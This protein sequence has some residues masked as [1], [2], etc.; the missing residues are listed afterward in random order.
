MKD[1]MLLKAL[2][3]KMLE[4]TGLGV[5][6]VTKIAQLV[7]S[8]RS[9][10]KLAF[11]D[12]EL[13]GYICGVLHESPFNNRRRVSDIG[14]YVAPDYRATGVAQNLVGSLEAWAKNK[15]ADELWLGQTTGTNPAKTA[16]FYTQLG[17][18]IKGFNAVKEL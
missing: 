8:D 11:S 12:D 2:T 10:V 1:V 16:D 5:A 6:T 15:A 7:S 14:V 18:K 17:Y 4:D 3:D 9:L 13:I